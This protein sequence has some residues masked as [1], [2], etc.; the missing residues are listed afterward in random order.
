M[1]R[2]LLLRLLRAVIG[3]IAVIRGGAMSGRVL[4]ELFG[5]VRAFEFMAFTGNTGKGNGQ[6]EQ[7]K[8]FHR[9]AS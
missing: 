4:M 7:G 8:K 2:L 9:R 3:L 1:S 6:D 5:A